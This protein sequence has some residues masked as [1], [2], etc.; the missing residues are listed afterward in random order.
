MS[1]YLISAIAVASIVLAY[2][3]VIRPSVRD[4]SSFQP[5]FDWIEPWEAR[6]WAKSRTVLIARL[7][8]LAGFFLTAHDLVVPM[9]AA[10]GF[11]PFLPPEWLRFMPLAI[12]VL[13]AINEWL[14]RV[15]IEPLSAKE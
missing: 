7:T 2:V 15:T 1:P 14:R 8:M 11:D 10:G 5:F 9:V 6:L 4:V 3:F 12:M 13:G